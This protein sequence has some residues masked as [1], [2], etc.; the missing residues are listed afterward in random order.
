MHSLEYCFAVYFPRCYATREINTKIPLPGA[1]KQFVTQIHTLLYIY[2][3]VSFLCS[4]CDYYKLRHINLPGVMQH[5][6]TNKQ[7]KKGWIFQNIF[8][9]KALNVPNDDMPRAISRVHVR[10]TVPSSTPRHVF[11]V[12]GCH[13]I[14]TL[15]WRHNWHDGVSNH[16]PHDCLFRCRS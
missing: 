5:Y 12:G 8:A 11:H 16:R 2:L 14:T 3:T 9:C 13:L 15:Q 7:Q 4:G 6:K 10:Y 1:H